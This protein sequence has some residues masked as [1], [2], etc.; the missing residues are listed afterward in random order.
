MPF[1]TKTHGFKDLLFLFFLVCALAIL[2]VLGGI[3]KLVIISALLAYILDPLVTTLELRGMTRTL[4]T[5]VLLLL[6]G[7]VLVVAAYILVPV[8]FDQVQS[9]QSGSMFEQTSLA[10]SRLE[11]IIRVKLG[12]LGMQEINLLE[13]IQEAKGYLGGRIGNF[14]IQ[15]AASLVVH[16]VF[17]PF[18]MFFLLKDGRKMKKD[19]VRLIPNR[20]FEFVLYLLYKMDMQLGNYL[21]GQFVDAVV[22]GVFSTIA[23]WLLNIKYFLF[24]GAFAG[25]ANLIPFVG[26]IAGVLPAV[27]VAVFD[28]GDVVRG[29]Y[30][31]VAFVVLKL[32]DDIIVQPLVVGK[33]VNLHPMLVGVAILVGGHVFGILGMLLAVPC[34]G[35]LKVVFVES[36]V[37]FRKYRFS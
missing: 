12:F 31:V 24:I 20:Y 32:L 19:F 2:L 30:V 8:L 14:L 11:T 26:P 21:R 36:I 25:L 1:E 10:I 35:F 28:T 29:G 23:L 4:A 37:T 33:S 6:I 9:L 18:I 7:F 27:A 5:V 3:A 15:D 13:K 22:F 17:I 34:A 16:A